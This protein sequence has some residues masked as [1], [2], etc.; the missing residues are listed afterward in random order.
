MNRLRT[1]STDALVDVPVTRHDYAAD[2]P[3]T[4]DAVELAGVDGQG[5][6]LRIVARPSGTEPKLKYYGQLIGS[7]RTAPEELTARLDAILRDLPDS[8]T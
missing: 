5:R 8:G 2:G 4:T 7:W 3:L 6:A 1:E